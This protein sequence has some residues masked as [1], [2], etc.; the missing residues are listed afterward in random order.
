MLCVESLI[1]AYC[2]LSNAS[3]REAKRRRPGKKAVFPISRY[4]K[5]LN[6][7]NMCW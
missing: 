1:D 6:I 7:A 4:P 3:S 2:S 5:M